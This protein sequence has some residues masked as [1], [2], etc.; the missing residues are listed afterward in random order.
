MK[1]YYF[2]LD[3]TPTHSYMKYLYKYPQ[4]AY[5]YSD[6]VTTNRTRGRH[7]LEYEL[8]D[9]GVFDDDR[10]FDVFVEYAKASPEDV[11][12]QI[13]VSNRGPEAATLHV[14]PT[15][16]FRNVW[17]WGGDVPRPTLTQ[18]DAGSVAASHPELGERR[19]YADG[20]P[21]WLFTE[22]ETNR[23]RFGRG[24]NA[25]PY[26]KDGIDNYVVHGQRH[27]V[28]PAKTGTKA[29]AHYSFTVGAGASHVIRLRLSEAPPAR[30]AGTRGGPSDRR[31]TR[32]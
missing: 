22:N 1:E 31:S 23:E 25:T 9:T 26:V 5:P 27:A 6:I 7:A 3:S 32:S 8:L 4:A 13:T 30:G 17:S 12:I 14:L 10:Y 21:E 15:I 19:F 20:A 28:N 11:L 2:Y 16:W 18:L 24:P 29:A